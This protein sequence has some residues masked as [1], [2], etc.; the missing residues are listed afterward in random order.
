MGFTVFYPSYRAIADGIGAVSNAINN[1]MANKIESDHK[2]DEELLNTT[3]NDKSWAIPKLKA[4]IAK[5]YK[6]YK[7]AG[8]GNFTV[9]PDGPGHL[10]WIKKLEAQLKYLES[11]S[12]NC[13]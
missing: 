8:G 1:A 4:L 5:R 11:C 10:T 12:E 9:N 3:C 7:A 6:Q 2:E 13:E